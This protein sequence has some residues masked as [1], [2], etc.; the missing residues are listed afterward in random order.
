[1]QDLVAAYK[2]VSHIISKADKV[3]VEVNPALLQEQAL[4]KLAKIRE[5]VDNFFEQVMVNAEDAAL[6]QNRLLI[7]QR[8]AAIL[9]TTANISVFYQ[10]NC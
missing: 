8:L 5:D 9:S 6:K 10:G 4:S 1:M 3:T 2:R 7:A